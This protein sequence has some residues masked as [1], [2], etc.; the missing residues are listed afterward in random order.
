MVDDFGKERA[1][2][3]LSAYAPEECVEGAFPEVR[4]QDPAY[5]RPDQAGRALISA[6]ACQR[7]TTTCGVGGWICSEADILAMGS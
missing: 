1:A 6:T 2:S 3:P 5:Y 7:P 4:M